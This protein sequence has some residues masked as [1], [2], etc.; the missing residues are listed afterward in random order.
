MMEKLFR[1]L[2]LGALLPLSVMAKPGN[3]ALEFVA[4]KGQWEGPFLYKA[5]TGNGQVFL[6]RN[7]FTYVI[8]APENDTKIKDFKVG[9][10]L[11]GVLNYH[12]YKMVFEGGNV[13]TTVS[14]SKLQQHYY[15]YFIGNDQTK[16]KSGI[17]PALALDYH[18]MYKNV[19][20]HIASDGDNM[21]YDLIVNPG[22]DIS[23][24]R[25]KYVGATSLSLKAGKLVIGTTV[26]NVEELKPYAYQIINGERTEVACKYKLDGEIVTFSFPYGYDETQMLVID[27]TVVFATF[28]GSSFDNWGYTAT[29]D[30]AGNFYAGGV[31]S[32]ASGGT[33]YP[34]LPA[35]G[36][37]QSTY[38]GGS[39]TSGNGFPC[40]ISISKFNAT[41]TA[42]VY[43]TY[44]GGNDNEQPHSLYVD[45]SGNLVIAGRSYSA[46]YPTTSGCYDNTYNGKGDL[47]VTLFNA[48]GT[49]LLG[50]TFVGGSEEDISNTTSAEFGWGGLKHNYGDDARSEVIM[51]NAGNVYI[52][53]CTKSSDFPTVNAIKTTLTSGDVQD[54]IVLKMNSSL[55]SLLWSTYLGGS[56]DDAAYVLTL[57]NSQTQL[58]VAGGTASSNF[59]AT[60]GTYQGTYQ[61]GIDGFIVRFQNGGSYAL[62]KGTF[63]G[64]SGYDQCY[65]VQVDLANNVYTMGQT[66]GGTFPVTG[67][68]YSNPGSSQFVMKLDNNL[69]ANMVSTVYGSGNSAATNISPVAFLVDTC[70]NVYISGWGGDIYSPN[71][72]P[73]TGTGTTV[74]MPLSTA[75]NPPAQATTDGADFYFI[76]FSKN[77]SALLYSTYMGRSGGVPEHVDG[78]TS[79]FDRNGV[80]YQAIC[81]ACGGGTFPTTAGVYKPT[82]GSSNCN[83]VALKIAMNLGRVKSQF[84]IT[85]N[86]ICAGQSITFTN[87]SSNAISYEWDFGDGSPVFTGTTP[88]AKTY[89]TAGSYI[90]RLIAVN[91][92]ACNVRDTA[93]T[94]LIVSNDKIDAAFAATV[95][96]TCFPY[97]ASFVNNSVYSPSP[98]G[99]VFT[100]DFGDGSATFTGVTP[101]NKNYPGAG[102]Y[103]VRLI[104]TDPIACNSPD[105]A[106][107]TVTFKND[108]VK[109]LFDV[110][111]L[112][113]IS[114][115]FR[116]TNRSKNGATYMWYFGDGKTSTST[117]ASHKYDTTGTYKVTL[118]AYNP[119]TCNRVDSTSKTITLYPSPTADFTYSPTVPETNVP[120]DFSN[121][122]QNAITFNWNF[123]DGEGSQDMN[124]SHTYKRS[125]N[126]SV[127][128]VAFNKE[129][130]S[131]TVCKPLVA[132]VKPLADVPSAF[133]PNGDGKNDILYVRGY[134][135]QTVNL[136]IYNRWGQKVFETNDMEVG[137]DGT[138]NGK[139]Q[140]MEAYGFVLSVTFT[141][142]S[143]FNKKGNVTL[144]R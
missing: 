8:G 44:L 38:G 7:T 53:A 102:T 60:S 26:G 88:P 137:W 78:G 64:R 91:S 75:P 114:D 122:S 56:S 89:N 33:G 112:N 108:S 58:F 92:S 59:P 107:Q 42:L 135:V 27:P 123:G 14:E 142:G 100:W 101:S 15:N 106:L 25:M 121:K 18:N 30:A 57:D 129:G 49:A 6:E 4:N 95:I 79:R 17:H 136:R 138:F 36:A 73:P 16:W 3:G 70:E 46:N 141:D 51:D 71:F 54:G 45:A 32:N 80:V 37:I 72:T 21:K 74:G 9:K 5:A 127:C 105:T 67:G 13:N 31:T 139:P 131:D 28:T 77:L 97:K 111:N 63:I 117:S 76:V 29:Y 98:A 2:I 68:V 144:L 62:Q 134:G 120:Y 69:A 113:C 118:I 66:M 109:A 82:N 61:G 103:T 43:S 115:S 50:S 110:P 119:A 87:N 55:T 81:G 116:V 143:S 132:D 20:V 52:A 140:E 23:K 48:T 99:T 85:P 126:Y 124:P 39:T 11:A 104:M 86:K 90:I 41:G 1:S 19:D 130:C 34:I 83:L 24:I 40:D 125:G 35:T 96:D 94:T 65:G 84:S 93:Y 10:S 22:A 128:L 47:V 133:S 12:A